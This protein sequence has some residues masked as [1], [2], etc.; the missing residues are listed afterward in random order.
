L[1]ILRQAITCLC[2]V[3]FY[4]ILFYYQFTAAFTTLSKYHV[5]AVLCCAVLCCAELSCTFI[6][7]LIS[8]HRYTHPDYTTTT[9]RTG[10]GVDHTQ[11]AEE[12]SPVFLQFLDCIF[13]IL[14][15]FPTCFEFSESLLI[16]LADH[17]HSGLF[18]T[19]LGNSYKQRMVEMKVRENTQSI[20]S[21]VFDNKD[22][23]C[24]S[25]YMPYTRPVWPSCSMAK[26]S[27][28]GR[29][30]NRWSADAHPNQVLGREAEWHDDWGAGLET[31]KYS[32]S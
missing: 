2:S 21:Y 8:P 22:R 4:S 16:F 13:Q 20:W 19:F 11:N 10:Q 15:Q 6:T 26:V 9:E 18:G 28:W 27:V 12:R 1:C 5:C 7:P 24:N 17:V 31:E 14:S 25:T 23:F 29:Y 3:K 30:F 32:F